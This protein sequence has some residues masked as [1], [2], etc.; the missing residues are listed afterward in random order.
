MEKKEE[1]FE[2]HMMFEEDHIY[3]LTLNPSNDCRHIKT[4][5]QFPVAYSHILLRLKGLKDILPTIRLFPE[6]ARG[7]TADHHNK[8]PRL[9]VHGDI[10][11]DTLG[12]YTYGCTKMSDT[13][14]YKIRENNNSSE[15]YFHKNEGQM[16]KWCLKYHLPYEI[17]WASIDHSMIHIIEW[18]KRAKK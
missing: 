12:F 10:T 15:V 16:K 18:A 7:E 2:S 3:G 5:Q 14:N 9:H 8:M 6:Y 1:N 17:T 4:V 13:F 11:L